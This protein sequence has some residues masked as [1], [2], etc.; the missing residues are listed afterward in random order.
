[1]DCNLDA[2]QSQLGYRFT[3]I[4]LLERA[5][6]HRS[7]GSDHNERLE[8]L[9]DSLV[10][11]A[12]AEMLFKKFPDSP[13]GEL[14]AMRS[15]LVCQESLADIARNIRIGD[16]LKL[17]EGTA[18]TGG[19]RL[20]SILSDAY[21]ALLGALY[22]DAGWDQVVLVI[23]QHFSSKLQTLSN[24]SSIRDAKSLLQEWLQAAKYPLP[25]YELLEVGGPG[26]AQRF[27]IRCLVEP[28]DGDFVGEGTS[29]RK[30]EQTAA[31]LALKAI[32][33]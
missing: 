10:N 14:S 19:H 6:S 31:Q 33:Q 4:D 8:F 1:M 17:G 24:V 27:R 23:Q 12:V 28:L 13:E 2:F 26:H 25:T 32:E 18:K 9:G 15:A 21:E 7:V 30:A 5:L 3:Q 29:R 11:M 22:L 20:D 16:F